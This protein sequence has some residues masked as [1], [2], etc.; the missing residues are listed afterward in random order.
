MKMRDDS[1]S[2][3]EITAELAAEAN[4]LPVELPL[5][6]GLYRCPINDEVLDESELVE[7]NACEREA[8]EAEAKDDEWEREYDYNNEEYWFCPKCGVPEN[9]DAGSHAEMRRNAKSYLPFGW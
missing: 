6:D 7:C 5:A 4:P 8:S 1:M 2:S 3:A 9:L